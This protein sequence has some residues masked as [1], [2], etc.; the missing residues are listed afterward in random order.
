MPTTAGFKRS[1]SKP[2]TGREATRRM[3]AISNHR[4]NSALALMSDA[5]LVLDE[6]GTV[7]AANDLALEMF[8]HAKDELVG[9]PVQPLLPLEDAHPRAAEPVPRRLKLQG[10]R[11]NGVP[12]PVEASVRPIEIEGQPRMLCAVRCLLYT[13]PSPRDRQRSRMPSSA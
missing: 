9:R 11:A 2:I 4:L 12:F 5:T 1:A 7:L 6:R 10:R 8:G 13:S 3:P